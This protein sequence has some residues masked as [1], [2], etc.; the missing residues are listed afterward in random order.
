MWSGGSLKLGHSQLLSAVLFHQ[1][2]QLVHCQHPKPPDH[3][4][5][6]L[7][8]MPRSA[9]LFNLLLRYPRHIPQ[10]AGGGRHGYETEAAECKEKD[11]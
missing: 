5:V 8:L 7:V 9:E 3:F 10:V 2:Q 1:D 4:E 6:V 11:D